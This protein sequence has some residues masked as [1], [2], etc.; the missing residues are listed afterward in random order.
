MNGQVKLAYWEIDRQGDRRLYVNGQEMQFVS[1]VTDCNN[2][3]RTLTGSTRW[4]ILESKPKGG[5]H[6]HHSNSEP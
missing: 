3:P 2:P 4:V 1:E 6:G 5:T